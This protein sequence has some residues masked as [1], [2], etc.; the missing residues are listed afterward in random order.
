MSRIPC[1]AVVLVESKSKKIVFRFAGEEK[2][3]RRFMDRDSF[4]YLFEF[5]SGDVKHYDRRE[6]HEQQVHSFHER[7]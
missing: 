1:D 7:L 5:V 4:L 3:T 2:K 6:L